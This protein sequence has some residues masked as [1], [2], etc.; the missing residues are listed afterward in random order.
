MKGKLAQPSKSHRILWKWLSAKYFLLFISFL[1]ALIVKSSYIL[2]GIY[3]TCLKK[4]LRQNLKGFQYQIWTSVKGLVSLILGYNCVEGLRVMKI[5]NQI[6]FEGAW[7]ELEAANCFQRQLSTKYLTQTLVL[8]Q[9]VRENF[10][11]CL[12]GDFNQYWKKF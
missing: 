5:V 8:M 10:N 3:F 6:N 2:S 4:R 7:G 9:K 12:S 1:T 11:F